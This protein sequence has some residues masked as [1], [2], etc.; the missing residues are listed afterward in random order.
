M[1]SRRGDGENGGRRRRPHGPSNQ[2]PGVTTCVWQVRDPEAPK[3]LPPRLANGRRPGQS[4]WRHVL[5][6]LPTETRTGR[7]NGVARCLLSGVHSTTATVTRPPRRRRGPTWPGFIVSPIAA[8]DSA[9]D[10]PRRT[11]APTGHSR[12]SRRCECARPAVAQIRISCRH[13]SCRCLRL[14][15]WPR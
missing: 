2:D 6:S 3:M 12:P 5:A 7:T 10:Q 11:D 14:W 1:P 9:R 15:K 4:P 13:R 8:G